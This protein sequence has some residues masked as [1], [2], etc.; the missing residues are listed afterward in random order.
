MLLIVTERGD[1][2]ADWLILELETRQVQFVRFNTE[3]YPQHSRLIWRND[4]RSALIIG[5][6]TYDLSDFDAIWYRRPV[7]PQ[8]PADTPAPLAAWAQ[9]EAREALLG[10][11]RTLD[12]LWVNHPDRNRVAESKLGQLRAARA[13][14][15]DV[16]STLVTNERTALTE[17]LDGHVHAICKPLYDGRVPGGERERVF[18]TSLLDENVNL[19]H[20][21]SEPY[22]FQELIDKRYDV[23]VTVIGDDV[24]AAR[25]DSQD[26]P[27]TRTD[28]RRSAPGDLQHTVETLP[29][30]VATLCVALCRHYDLSFGAIDLARRVDGGYSFFEINPNGQWAWVEQRTGLPLR[31]RLADLLTA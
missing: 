28:W 7:P 23:R 14:G 16:P 1:F 30:D 25:I 20:L 12:A 13:L 29:D 10:A 2:H 6:Q 26:Q 5:S 8:M 18:F 4:D 24:F 21:G 9:L 19:D 31:A 17:F 11:W 15:F 3:D 22:L 27:E